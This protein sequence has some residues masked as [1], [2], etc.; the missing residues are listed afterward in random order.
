MV[1][2]GEVNYFERK[3]FS[4]VVACIP[5]GDRQGDPSKVD[6]LLTR[7]Y[8]VKWVWAA[9]EFVLGKPQSLKGIEVHEVEAAAPVHEGLGE[10]GCP[11]QWVDDEGIPS[12]LGDAIRVV[13]PVESDRRFGP[14]QVSL[15]LRCDSWGAG[16]P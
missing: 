2:T 1:R 4:A 10:P 9:L 7:D 15:N 3:Y 16:L 14:V 11:D 8:S 12:W 6:G 13:R 5:E